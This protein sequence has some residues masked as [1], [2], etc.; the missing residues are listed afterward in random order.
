MKNNSLLLPGAR[1][2]LRAVSFVLRRQRGFNPSVVKVVDTRQKPL[3]Q[4]QRLNRWIKRN[5]EAV[6]RIVERLRVD[7]RA[8]FTIPEDYYAFGGSSAETEAELATWNLA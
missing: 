2:L 3:T 7:W 8:A 5:P 6:A 1:A 4:I